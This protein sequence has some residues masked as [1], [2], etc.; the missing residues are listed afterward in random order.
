MDTDD[1][2]LDEVNFLRWLLSQDVGDIPYVI[3]NQSLTQYQLELLASIKN[4]LIGMSS[5]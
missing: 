1:F 4:K 2:T 3:I 5:Y